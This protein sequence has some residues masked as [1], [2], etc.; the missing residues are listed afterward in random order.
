MSN[1]TLHGLPFFQFI[2]GFLCALPFKT[3]CRGHR[4]CKIDFIK[5][6]YLFI[7]CKAYKLNI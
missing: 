3:Y 2:K 6:D 5:F 7:H 1:L 4:I